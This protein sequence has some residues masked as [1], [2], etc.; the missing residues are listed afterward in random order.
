MRLVDAQYKIIKLL[1]AF[2]TEIKAS[3]AMGKSDFSKA[4]ETILIPI[5]AELYG[6]KQL[7]NLNDTERINFPGID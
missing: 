4:S 6:Y 5:F 3:I 1:S 2:V 7:R